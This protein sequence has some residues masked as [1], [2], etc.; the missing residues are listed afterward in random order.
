LN[1]CF[2]QGWTYPGGLASADGF[3]VNDAT[4]WKN[5]DGLVSLVS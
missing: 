1:G 2:R 3:L 5:I 4:N